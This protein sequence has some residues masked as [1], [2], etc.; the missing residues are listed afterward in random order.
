MRRLLVLVVIFVFGILSC[1]LVM[2]D[3]HKF[4]SL[5]ASF[6]EGFLPLNPEWATGL[7]EHRYD[8]KV[9]DYS[10][11]GI[12]K[13]KTFYQTY[14]DS[15]TQIDPQR[16]NDT[17]HID[18]EI[19]KNRLHSMVFSLD[20]LRYFEWNPRMYNPA[21]S[22][23]SLIA[24]EFAPLP[25]RMASVLER[26]KAIPARLEQARA[27]LGNPPKIYTVTAIRQNKGAVSFIRDDLNE[28]LDKVPELKAEFEPVQM[29]AVDALEEYGRWL[30]NDLL[31]KSNGNFRLGD[32]KFRAKLRYTLHSDLPKEDILKRAEKDL[33]ATQN[34]IYE[35]AL[36][37]FE[38][39]FPKNKKDIGNKKKVVKEVL[40]KL[41]ENRPNA[42]NVVA[43]AEICLKMCDDFVREK[44]F[45]TVP[46]EPINI[47]VMPEFQRGVAVA[48]CDSP[49]PLE[50]EGKTFYAISPPPSHWDSS[51]VESYF[52]EYNEHMMKDLTIHEAMPGH[53]LQLAHSNDFSAPTMIR[54]I[55]GSGTFTEGWA[56]YAEQLMVEYDFGG[57][58]SKMQMLKMRLRMII[59]AII[60]QKIH[61]AGMTEKEAMDMMLDEGF[62]E[63]GEAA[64]K[65]IRA[66]LSSTQLSTY[67]VGNIEINDIRKSYEEKNEGTF[68][69]KELH[70]KML[71]FGSPPPKYVKELMGL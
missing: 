69:I 62:Q 30:E 45:I 22:I 64:G 56:T 39:F 34:A 57:P 31:P 19:L 58:E 25:E 47:I 5:S 33:V 29:A 37:L 68:D 17:N 27:N 12:E 61:T 55:F 53:Y 38:E 36:P 48:Y 42:E 24:R 6:F 35:T 14:I 2:E 26:L 16:L 71:S 60:D 44:G 50:K 40:N 46:D 54:S 23:Y 4:E 52:K 49:G 43:F 70:D 59:N 28:H 3:N 7:G 9:S 1:S 63:E 21:G 15:L 10:V 51:R 66:C 13:K 32:E 11:D 8:Y 41:A 18:Y 65:W 20:T 67:Y